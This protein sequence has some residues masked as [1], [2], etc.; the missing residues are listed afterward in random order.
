MPAQDTKL[1][2]EKERLRKENRILR[3]ESE[4]QKRKAAMFCAAHGGPERH[5]NR[6]GFAGGSNS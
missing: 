2:R 5:L 1:V 3:E 6:T 4:V